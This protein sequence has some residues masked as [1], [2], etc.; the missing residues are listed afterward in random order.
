L[1]VAAAH[2]EPVSVKWENFGPLSNFAPKLLLSILVIF[3]NM[4]VWIALSLPSAVFI[5][6]LA[7][8]PGVRP[9]FAQN[10]IL[11]LLIAVGNQLIALVV[12][13]VTSWMG[14]LYK[15]SRDVAVLGLAFIGTLVATVFDLCVVAMTAHGMVLEDAFHGRDAGYEPVVANE[16]FGLTVPGYLVLPYLGMPLGEHALPYFLAKFL[17]RSHAKVTLRSATK[18]MKSA[19]FDICWRYSDILNNTT[20]CIVLLFFCSN[21]AWMT[22]SVLFLFMVIIYMIDKYLLLRV[23]TPTVYD[24]HRL[25][26]AFTL[27]WCLPTTML[28]CLISHWGYRSGLISSVG[29]CFAIPIAHAFFFVIALLML[30]SWLMHTDDK[31]PVLYPDMIRRLQKTCKPWDYFNTNP[32]FCLRTRCH[33]ADETGWKEV[34]RFQ[35]SGSS[36]YAAKEPNTGSSPSLSARTFLESDECLPFKLGSL[37]VLDPMIKKQHYIRKQRQQPVSP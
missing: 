4:F 16:L 8:I 13:L 28:A 23:A 14:F 9:G 11:G 32:V 35:Q 12:D 6:D 22:M 3:L 31:E 5:A 26:S 30:E 34:V 24:T 19:D 15:D 27:W 20:I 18:A 7:L 2:C 33:G 29:V 1:G 10:L 37:R 21:R 25:S 17:I 36:S